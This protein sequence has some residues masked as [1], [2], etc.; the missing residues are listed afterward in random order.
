MSVNKIIILG[1]VGKK[2]ELAYTPS[3]TAVCRFSVATNHK[4]KDGKGENKEEV[5]WHNVSTWGDTAEIV[6]KYLKKGSKVYVEGR[7]VNRSYEK[8]G[9]KRYSSEIK[10]KE[11][12]TLP[13]EGFGNSPG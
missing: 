12:Q 5:T 3:G 11:V 8:D 10:A 4:W 2:P 9:E 13:S 6:N 1:N 7:L